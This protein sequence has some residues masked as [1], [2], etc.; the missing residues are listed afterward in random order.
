MPGCTGLSGIQR[1]GLGIL[2]TPDKES[3]PW[4]K[5]WSFVGNSFASDSLSYYLPDDGGYVNTVLTNG[6]DAPAIIFQNPPSPIIDSSL[7]ILND[8]V[9]AKK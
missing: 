6:K 5:I 9:I 4:G 3:T 2:E 8:D 1:Y 7:E